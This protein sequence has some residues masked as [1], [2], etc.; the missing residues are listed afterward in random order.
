MSE[1]GV[2]M[3]GWILGVD[4]GTSNTA[5]AHTNI[6]SGNVETLPLSHHG[7]LMPSGVFV[8]SPDSILVGEV[9]LNRAGSNPGGF[10]PAPKRHITGDPLVRAN[11]Y[12]LPVQ[13]TVAA[14]LKTVIAR[15]VRVHGGQWPDRIV[16]THPEN[17]APDQVKI[18]VESAGAAGVPPDRVATVSEPRAAAH[19]YTRTE[20]LEPG[21]KLAVF[22]YGGGTLDIA[23]LESTG[24][25]T[26]RV[27]AAGGNN[28]LGG[29]N[30]DAQLRRWVDRQL[31][32]RNPDLL[33]YIQREAP[34]DVLRSLEE[35]IRSAKELLSESAQA[36]ITLYDGRHD[37]RETF[38][39]TRDEFNDVI[40][41]QIDRAVLL[42]RDTFA[43][44]GLTSATD[45]KAVYLTGGSSRIPLVHDRLRSLGP[46]A[47]LDD[48]K[49]VV[50]QGAIVANPSVGAEPAVA[51]PARREEPQPEK[52]T[53][54]WPAPVSSPPQPRQSPTPSEPRRVTTPQPT[55]VVPSSATGKKR[56]TGAIA[57]GA[58]LVVALLAVGGFVL[59][60]S[61]SGD[62]NSGTAE[63]GSSQSETAATSAESRTKVSDEDAIREFIPKYLAV[64]GK[65][66]RSVVDPMR[67]AAK[68]RT[69]EAVPP[70]QAYKLDEIIS[71]ST[72][73][74][75][76]SARIRLDYTA[77]GKTSTENAL[78]NFAYE[79]NEWKFCGE[80][81]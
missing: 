58:I 23:V 19:Y 71:V 72:S 73:G 12:D 65:A 1:M 43:R 57:T 18:L 41:E 40:G 46:I 34:V 63:A 44:A 55:P 11:N 56:P 54:G 69:N 49:T 80:E 8:E 48:P 5:A 59:F 26:F 47:T 42:T 37:R 36:T 21:A 53:A 35:S 78:L 24:N 81:S 62:D 27:S 70:D 38:L 6:V 45:L 7:N 17:W 52:P 39:L 32:D 9:A 67:C 64:A 31:A 68:Q 25:G 10:V 3:P 74:D 2:G 60:R 22:D 75:T 61:Q 13:L 28:Q 20:N 14:V 50:A 15:A 51:A 66:E 4:F 33:S 30:I 76:G 29:K 16:L 77:N 79:G